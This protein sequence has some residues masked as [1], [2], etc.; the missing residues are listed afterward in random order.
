M[1]A[2][3]P[4]PQPPGPGAPQRGQ[5]QY[6]AVCWVSPLR[7][8]TQRQTEMLPLLSWESSLYEQQGFQI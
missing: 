5:P 3:A 6:Q 8:D 1:L 2:P 4:T 7:A